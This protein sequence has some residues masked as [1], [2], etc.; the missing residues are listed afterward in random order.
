MCEDKQSICVEKLYASSLS[1]SRRKVPALDP[2]LFSI[3][4]NQE[5]SRHVCTEMT[6]EIVKPQKSASLRTYTFLCR[7]LKYHKI[8]HDF[9]T[10]ATEI[11]MYPPEDG[12][13]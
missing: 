10:R 9:R 4:T 11:V 1:A 7:V 13:E 8:S 6:P 3:C 2:F 12:S 5:I